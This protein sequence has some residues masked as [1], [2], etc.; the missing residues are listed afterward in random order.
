M[1]VIVD[2]N[3]CHKVLRSPCSKE[4]EPV[5]EWIWSGDGK[6]IYGGKLEKEMRLDSKTKRLL[7]QWSRAGK[8]IKYRKEDMADEEKRIHGSGLMKSNDPHVLALAVVSK[9]RTLCTDDKNLWSDFTNKSLVPMKDCCVYRDA[10][11]RPALK[12]T[13]GCKG[14]V[15]DYQKKKIK[16]KT[17][18]K[19]N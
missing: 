6:L 12:H 11:D 2:T 7:I 10:K 5:F 9:T 16:Q 14:Y 18:K 3:C 1:C 19:K 15:S 13:T 17:E 4:Y 8:A